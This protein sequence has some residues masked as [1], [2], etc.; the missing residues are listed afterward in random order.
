M[1]L[2]KIAWRSIQQRSLASLLTG[3]SMALGVAL[4]IAVLVVYSVIDTKFRSGGS[5]FDLIIGAKGGK[6]QLVLNTVYHL[7][8]PI[9]NIPWSYYK[10]F[11]D[12]QFASSTEFAIPLCMGDSYVSEDGSQIFRVVGTTRDLFE[13]VEYGRVAD[14]SSPKGYRE[15][16]YEFAQGRNFEP[17]HFYEAVIGSLVAR[18]TGLKVGDA[19]QPSHG[20]IEEGAEGHKHEDF[21][22]V[23]VLA[24]S[25]TP[26]DRAMFV[27]IEGFYLLEG[28]AKAGAESGERSAESRNDHAHH[29]HAHGPHKP[30]PE[31]QR[32]VT[33]LLV[34]L[35]N[36]LV[37]QRIFTMVNEG[38]VAQAVFPTREVNLLF[39]RIVGPMQLILLILTV[40]IVIV[41]GIGIMVSIYNSMSD[42]QHEI[43]VMRALGAG[44]STVMAVVL[45]ESILL[46]LSGGVAGVLL[47][48]GI[49]GIMNPYVVDH[50]G[51]EL[52]FLQF[53]PLELI[54][55]PAL[56]ILASIVG[57]VP[58]MS[59]YRTDVA[60]ALSAHP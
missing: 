26:N 50:T 25:G 22:V 29:D 6:L 3:L 52:S 2:L 9:E 30:L 48:H 36:P 35:N 28:H 46:S 51:V 20:I 12:G 10:E 55:I 40:M 13:R 45:L 59:A 32:E 39:D 5:G 41:A 19:F 37:S 23:G 43:A 24:P 53:D 44:R 42:R 27:N 7:S 60:K 14:S 57:F 17:D 8:Q 15:L 4:V 18:H 47:G 21:R 11:T 49:I 38:P 31:S 1:N 33:A 58:A 34:L 54:L 16:K 56:V